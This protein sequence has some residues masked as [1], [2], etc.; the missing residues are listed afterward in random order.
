[1]C[2]CVGAVD[3]HATMAQKRSPPRIYRASNLAQSTKFYI[4]TM[5]V[6]MCEDSLDGQGMNIYS[7]IKR[8]L[9]NTIAFL[10]VHDCGQ[11][12]NL[13][14]WEVAQRKSPRT[15]QRQVHTEA[16]HPCGRCHH[17]AVACDQ[18]QVKGGLMSES[19]NRI[20]RNCS[21]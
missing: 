18:T 16:R 5:R 10:P 11:A 13:D 12:P 4:A 3:C 19:T 9:S 17:H 14:H 21:N 1:M 6:R 8:R 20:P 2:P 15:K 7:K